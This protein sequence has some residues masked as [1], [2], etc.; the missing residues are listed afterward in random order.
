MKWLDR[1]PWTGLVFI[2][3]ILGMLPWPRADMPHLF[4]KLGMLFNG[5]L[6]RPIDIFDL[7]LH[8]APAIL[9]L[10]KAVRS[11]LRRHS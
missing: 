3:I 8:G 6:S 11:L 10:L 7:L 5:T 4:E 2:T 9:L 1:L